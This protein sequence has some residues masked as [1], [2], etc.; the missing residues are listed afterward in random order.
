MW[1]LAD[2]NK[3]L[4]EHDHKLI[5]TRWVITIKGDMATPG[6]RARLVAQEVN[7]YK[8]DE[9]FASTP[10]LE[11]K[12][13]LFSELTTRRRTRNGRALE[14]SFLDIKKAYFNA[15]PRRLLHLFLPKEMGL[16]ARAV[17]HL[18]RCVYDTR[19]AGMLWEE[20]YSH[21]LIDL[22]FRRGLASPCC[23][24]NKDLEVAVVI[25]GDDFTA[26]GARD[27]L[28]N[29]EEGP[30][31]VFDYKHKGR[32]GKA[33]DCDPEVRVLNRIVS[34]G[35]SGIKYEAD[36][37]HAE[38]LILAAGLSL[39]NSSVTPGSKLPNADIDAL[40]QDQALDE[41]RPGDLDG[42]FEQHVLEHVSSMVQP[43]PMPRSTTMRKEI[44]T[45]TRAQPGSTTMSP[46]KPRKVQ[47]VLKPSV[48]EVVA[49][50]VV[51]GIHPS[52]IVATS[53]GV[54]RKVKP[55][56]DPYTGK[57]QAVMRER[58]QKVYDRDRLQEIRRRRA[59]DLSTVLMH[60]ASWERVEDLE[61]SLAS[62]LE[63]AKSPSE[64]NTA[65]SRWLFDHPHVHEQVVTAVRTPSAQSKF[66]KRLG[67]R[68][69]RHL[70]HATDETSTLTPAG[71]TSFRA[72]S[73]RC[74]Y[75][76]QDRPDIV[77]ASKEVCRD[78]AASTLQS[79]EQ[80]KKGHTLPK[81]MPSAHLQIPL[82][83]RERWRAPILKSTPTSRAVKPRGEALAAE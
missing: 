74:N 17:A 12:R 61:L 32:I 8:S 30:A 65:I 23:F 38:M 1:E 52:S 69:V 67:A 63:I 11:A 35:S 22:G 2:I 6:V 62:L 83:E 77:F 15:I 78:F 31:K 56:S 28:L 10:P 58:R 43:Q 41:V 42:E 59:E 7:T 24:W 44:V 60:G 21:A 14:L 9:F 81:G 75:L 76:A 45:D 82:A 33:P 71:A 19:D 79:L 3:V 5:R 70:E 40:L 36:P 37:R 4:Q 53:K 48:R 49:Y 39:G 20:T 13:L 27:G 25:H 72:P 80:L 46:K 68:K 54:F 16:G 73:A 34:M 29:C 18:K 64:R 57:S 55:E 66:Q 47:F 50:S 51:Y 26:L